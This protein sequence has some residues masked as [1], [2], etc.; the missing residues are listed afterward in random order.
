[1]KLTVLCL[2]L[3]F[4]LYSSFSQVQPA[5]DPAEIKSAILNSNN[6]RV[7]LYNYGQ[8]TRPNTLGNVADFAW[9]G[10]GNMYEFGPLIAGEVIEGTDTTKILD[11]G[12]W[13]PSQGGYSPDGTLKWGWLP[14]PGYANP[15]QGHLATSND[16]SSWPSSWTA[17]PGEFGNGV[18]IGM[19]EA[20][21]G[22]D[23]FTNRKYP[24]YPFPS[25]SS[26]RGLGVSAE[27]RTYQFGGNLA[28]AVFMK[29]KL[30][31]DSPKD[32]NRCYFGFYGD[33]H[34]GGPGD[35][36][37]DLTFFIGPGGPLGDTARYHGR[38]TIYVWD[39]NGVG[40]GG[41]PTGYMGFKFL[42]TPNN[43]DLTTF[44][45]LPY[46][47]SFPNVPKNDTLFWRLLATDSIATNQPLFT[48]PGDNI[49]VFGSGPFSMMA[50]ESTYVSLVV[51]FSEDYQDMVDDA[52]Y[53]HFASH[54]PNISGSTGAGG[55]DPDYAIQLTG[56]VGVVSG[57][58]PVTWQYTGTDP[59]ARVL[60]ECSWDRGTSWKPIVWEHPVG[61]P[62][63]WNTA[64]GRDG[65]NYLLRIVAYSNDLSQYAYDVSDQRFTVNNPGNAQPELEMDL[66][67]EG[68]TVRNPPLPISWVAEDADNTTLTVTV[69]YAFD[70]AGPFTTVFSQAVQAGSFTFHWDFTQAPNSSSYYL[71]V[72]ASDGARDTT[73]ISRSF[74]IDYE[75]GHYEPTVFE[76]IAGKATPE[77]NLQ[78]VDPT[79]LTRHAY[80]LSFT[81][82][83]PDSTK[84]LSIRDT[85]T[86][87]NVVSNYAIRPDISTPLFDGLKLRVIDL[88]P[89][90]NLEK[91]GFNRAE[92]DTTVNF[93]WTGIFLNQT[94]LPLDWYLAFN[95]LDTLPDGR[96]AF[97][98]DTLL[99]QFGQKRIVCPFYLVNVD[100]MRPGR[101]LVRETT[102]FNDRWDS[103]E[104]IVLYEQ[105]PIRFSYQVN[106]DFSSAVRPG[107]GDTLWIITDKPLT[108]T[109]LFRFVADSNYIVSVTPRTGV[110][111]Y[112]LTQNYPN[113]FNP[114]TTI[115]YSLP[116]SGGVS[117]KIY[118][119]LGREVK[120]VVNEVQVAG[121]YTV[122][123]HLDKAATGVYFYRLQ[124][125]DFVQT[126]KLLFLK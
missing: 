107:A 114:T 71:R 15:A 82:T 126:K 18:V 79:Q 62:Y 48:T 27:V 68:T 9:R 63:T 91:S 21:Y 110:S 117:L 40:T 14:R 88:G 113:P 51:F 93:N 7:I 86:G 8:Y 46:T 42:K 37:D 75:A 24:Y 122:Q 32:I 109:D 13:L 118:D 2:V 57:D 1:M 103:D 16:T 92:L 43:H 104:P 101:G 56:P 3:V 61:Q 123:L 44:F 73:L 81:V 100:S 119:L 112:S 59:S 116:R 20:S 49:V 28:D 23:D 64:A 25:D 97:P 67:F 105:P 124:A 36:A 69:Q 125:G 33:P 89:D 77:L 60:I 6:V 90:I 12:L 80:E 5:G 106:L 17:W 50:G 121:E 4:P 76:H 83:H 52:N 10:L 11:D 96:Y 87:L 41:Q 102:P 84:F 111:A 31:N 45:A 19:N 98:G 29:W 99:N 120:T 22:M 35:F 54:W 94:K 53:V 115:R 30:K 65:V 55:G 39:A 70:Q 58:V 74:A 26:K 78:A 72:I 108:A 47:N 85:V 38:N 34:I 95:P 66:P